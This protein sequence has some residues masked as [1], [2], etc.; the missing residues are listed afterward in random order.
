MTYVDAILDR[1]N[2]K[3]HV[4]ERIDG[5]RIFTDYATEYVLYYEHPQGAYKT[6]WQ[7]PCHKYST[8]KYK[9][10]QKELAVHSKDIL[11]ESDINPIFRCLENN[12][13]GSEPSKLNIGFFD[14]EVDFDPNRGF[15]NPWNP[16]AR[17]TAI[18]IYLNNLDKL[19][20]LVLKPDVPQIESHYLSTEQ[21]TK[22]TDKFPDC[23]L[24]STEAELLTNFIELISD[25]DVLSGWNS[26]SYDIPYLINRTELVMGKRSSAAYCLWGRMPKK[27]DFVKFKKKNS[28]YDLVGRVHLDYLD[29]YMKHNQQQLHSYRLD[30]VGEIE[31]GEN[32][33]P[34]EGSLDTLYKKDFEKFIS[35]NRQDTLLL[36][37]IDKRRKFIEL[38]DQ[39]AHT[40][41]VLLQTTMGAVALV[42]QAIINEAHSRGMVVYNKKS[43]IEVTDDIDDFDDEEE[44]EKATGPAVGAYVAIP[45]V[46]IHEHIGCVDIKS[47]YPSTLR[48]LNMGP[49]TIVGQIRGNYTEKLIA[50]T[51]SWDNIFCVKEFDLV[52][53][54]T[55]DILT[56][57][58]ADG[59]SENITAKDLYEF[60]FDDNNQYC[61]S[62]NGTIFR[63]DIEAIIP[64]LLKKWYVE[65][66]Q[67]Q[68]KVEYFKGLAKA[69]TDPAKKLEY[70][71][72]V[73][74]WDQRQFARKILLNSLY[75]G[76]LNEH[77]RFYSYNIGQ[78]TTLTGRSIVKHQN[79]YI[80]ETITGIY[81]I[82]GAAVI[83]GDTDS[84]Y[85]SIS[86]MLEK[87]IDL[88]EALNT[89]EAMIT[90]YDNIG[91]IVNASFPM[92]MDKTFHTGIE[93]GSIISAGR[94]LVGSKGLFITPKRYAILMYD[95][96]GTRLDVDGKP[97]KIKAMGLDSKRSDTPK[98][99]QA[100]LEKILLDLLSGAKEEDIQGDIKK[101]RREFR[102]L[103][104]WQKG[105]PKKVNAVI[106]FT[107]RAK[108]KIE[109]R[110][111]DTLKVNTAKKTTT[112]P[113]H[114]QASLNW[115][116]LLNTNN[117]RYSM[118]I[119]DG[120]KVIVC[121][122]KAGNQ[123]GMNS[124]AYPID[125]LHLPEW[126]RRL[127]FDDDAME[128]AII[129][130][131]LDNLLGV[132]KWN[133]GKSKVDTGFDNL[134]S[135]GG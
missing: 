70:Q 97:G 82:N 55:D 134:F 102:D 119:Q 57:D 74:F 36:V 127:P 43:H 49:E 68:E 11:H 19:V 37:K 64:G 10:F 22:I 122:L 115:N 66:Q 105:T 38:A 3:I 48:A 34:Y 28:T 75:G 104:G 132:L 51:K 53:D 20:T 31:V 32:K 123:F 108:Q 100:F 6:M 60:I 13:L 117:D 40:N 73:D 63:T 67:M 78:S 113:G 35:Y 56:I 112:V 77:C 5:K 101:F 131:K 24:C 107:N 14:I 62:A 1:A 91:D 121:K 116:K 30:F 103:P 72:E 110:E 90:F 18:S 29:L 25:V 69:E 50:E 92:F 120:Q 15:A 61:L 79:S 21:A 46:G 39:L 124:I 23:H 81:Q 133:L 41:T 84:S 126:F 4:V 7:K 118:A 129:D 12:Y 80:N 88:R 2:D 96:E 45:K 8:N 106:D 93:R 128:N 125:E 130:K 71:N 9:V 114:V 85:F 33:I 95:K 52:H 65:R 54:K 111:L 89:R 44:G 87:D 16:F 42:E 83:Y 17:I 135:F 109:A 59:N 94:E 98:V 58:Y 99:M 47:L 26:T 76:L 86:P 27:R